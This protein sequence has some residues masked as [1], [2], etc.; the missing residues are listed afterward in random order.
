MVTPASNVVVLEALEPPP[1]PAQ[2]STILFLHGLGDDG[3]GTGYGLAQKFQLYQKLPHTRWVLPTAA[4]DPAVGQRCWYKPPHAWRLSSNSPSPSALRGGLGGGDQGRPSVSVNGNGSKEDGD[5][6]GKGE[7]EEDGEED[8]EDEAGILATVAHIDAL[9]ADEV[10]RGGVDPGRIVVGGFSQGCAV[11]M[12]WGLL[13]EWRDQVAGVCGLSGFLPQIPALPKEEDLVSVVVDDDDADADAAA[14][15]ADAGADANAGA[16]S[17]DEKS[18]RED[19][20][21]NSRLVA[22]AAKQWF[23]GHGMSDPLVSIQMFAEGQKRLQGLVDRET[24]EGHVYEGLAHDIGGAEIRDIWLWLK[25]VLH[26]D[27]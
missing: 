23:F 5:G 7:E 22:R 1:D 20:K 19:N 17:H 3:R 4:V 18:G 11:S 13:G 21:N 2:R 27:E 10:Q 26:E 16:G 6:N 24:V 12:A 15:G 25:K 9:V 8:E 14:A